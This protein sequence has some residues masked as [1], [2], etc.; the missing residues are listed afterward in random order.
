MRAYAQGAGLT[1]RPCWLLLTCAPCLPPPH[2]AVPVH[3]RVHAQG[4]GSDNSHVLVLA[5]TN[6]PY[7]LDQAI[8]RRFDKRIYIP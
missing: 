1:T 3:Y 2:T 7:N 6:L 8:R 5:A 4:V